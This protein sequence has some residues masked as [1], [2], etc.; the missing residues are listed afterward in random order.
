LAGRT[1]TLET[2]QG[3]SGSIWLPKTSGEGIKVDI[4]APTFPWKDLF[5]IIRPDTGGANSPTLAAYRG[6]LCREFF[7]GVND[8]LDM[9]Y[10]IN[11]DYV[12]NSDMYIHLHWGHNGTAISGSFIVNFTYSYSKGHN[13]ATF[14]AEKQITMSYVTVDIT[15]TPQYIHRIDETQ[16]S[17]VGGSGTLL[18]TS[19]IEPDGVITMNMTVT[20]IPTITGGTQVKPFICFADIH[21][22]STNI[23]TKQKTPNFYE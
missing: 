2:K 8:K 5:G 21:Y 19:L 18:D 13:Q 9:D 17:T 14:A 11:H 3:F 12:P 10:H 4:S 15:T 22:Q 23:G 16:L 1:S 6:G 7:Y 20:E